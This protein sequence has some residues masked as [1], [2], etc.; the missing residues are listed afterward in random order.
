MS[1]DYPFEINLALPWDAAQSLQ[2]EDIAGV[3]FDNLET[4]KQASEPV[5]LVTHAKGSAEVL[6][7]ALELQR[8][9]DEVSRETGGSNPSATLFTPDE[10]VHFEIKASQKP[11]EV[12]QLVREAFFTH[13]S[14]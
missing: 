2:E 9:L 10:H 14:P 1:N 6:Q 3:V 13:T 12:E 4:Q 11:Q 8:K 5:T 7:L